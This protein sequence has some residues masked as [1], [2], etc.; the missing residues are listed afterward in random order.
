VTIKGKLFTGF[1]E[2]AYYV[3]REGYKKQFVPKL[4]F[5]P[6]PG[7]LNLKLSGA[8]GIA[9]R[10]ELEM[11]PG[12]NIDGFNDETRTYGTL[13]SFPALINNTV[14]GAVLLIQRS[15]YNSSVIEVIAPVFLRKALK[16]SDNNLV[17]LKILP[18]T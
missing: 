12:V 17:H 6:Y 16:I 10:R 15:H 2:G 1:G 7:T 11:L 13:K 9:S 18:R 14:K 8:A 3:T 4:G 5:K